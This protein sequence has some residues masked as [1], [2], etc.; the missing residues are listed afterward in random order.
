MPLALLTADFSGEV[1]FYCPAN[2]SKDVKLKMDFDEK[3]EQVVALSQLQR[4]I[5]KMKLDWFSGGKKYFKEEV[6]TVK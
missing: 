2:S 1:Y 4:G 6:I 3:G 5:Y